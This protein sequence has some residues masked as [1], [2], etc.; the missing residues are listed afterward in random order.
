MH[1]DDDDDREKEWV[2]Y[3]DYEEENVDDGIYK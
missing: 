1:D 3:G 2:G